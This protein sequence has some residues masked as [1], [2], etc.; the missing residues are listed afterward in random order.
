MHPQPAAHLLP[1]ISFRCATLCDS[2]GSK[3]SVGDLGVMLTSGLFAQPGK[4]YLVDYC[5][6]QMAILNIWDKDNGDNGL[7]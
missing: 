3:R 6:P 5:Q 7:A 2:L 1:K 4:L